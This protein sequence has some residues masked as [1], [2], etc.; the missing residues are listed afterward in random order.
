MAGL[1]VLTGEERSNKTSIRRDLQK[2]VNCLET[3][4]ILLKEYDKMMKS[5]E[6]EIQSVCQKYLQIKRVHDQHI[7]FGIKWAK[8]VLFL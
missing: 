3:S 6:E 7:R 5:W 2:A 8:V 1:Q 4:H